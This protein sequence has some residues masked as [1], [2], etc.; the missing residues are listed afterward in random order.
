MKQ[1]KFFSLEE[2]RSCIDSI[3]DESLDC[4]EQ[5]IKGGIAQL[6]DFTRP[7]DNIISL[8]RKV[9]DQFYRQ[10]ESQITQLRPVVI[11]PVATTG[12]QAE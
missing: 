8:K 2:A 10:L 5:I 7:L 1:E 6:L 11:S 12:S 4:Q 9:S 3:I